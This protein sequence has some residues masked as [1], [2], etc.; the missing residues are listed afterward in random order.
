MLDLNSLIGTT[1]RPAWAMS[2]PAASLVASGATLAVGRPNVPLYISAWQT[3]ADNGSVSF[4]A[5]DTVQLQ[6][7]CCTAAG[8]ITIGGTL[9]ADDTTFTNNA[10]QSP[11]ITVE[12]GGDL[13]LADST[14]DLSSL[15]LDSGSAASMTLVSFSG[16]FKINSG[17]NVGTVANPTITGNDFSNVGANGIVASGDPNAQIPFSGN[18]WG[19]TVI[20]QIAAKIDD[21]NDNANLP[22]IAYQPFVS[23]ASGTVAS[24]VS[25]TF[26]PTNQTVNLTATVST[27]AGVAINEGTETFTILN[28]TQVIGQTTAPQNVSNGAVMA[29]YTLPG[30]T[31]AGQYIIEASYSG[32]AN[33]L[34]SIDTQHFLT[35]NPAATTTTVSNASATFNSASDQTVPLSAQISSMAGTVN[36]GTVTFTILFGGNPVGSP[37]TANVVNDAASASYD[38]LANTKGGS[39]TIETVYSDPV[40]FKT[41][42]GT[43]LLTVSAAP[44][45]ITPS[46]AATTFN[47]VTGEGITLSA[48][49][50]SPAGT[51][52]QGAVTFTILNSSSQQVVPPI[53]VNTL[54]GIASNNYILPAGTSVGSYTIAAVYDG[55]SSYAASLPSN[56]TLTISGA[57][58]SIAAANASIG[59][60]AAVQSA[61]LTAT[62]TSPGGT[63]SEGMVTFTILS[64]AT[65]IG[66]P[67][68]VNV[69]SGTAST[70]YPLPAAFALGTYTIK[71]VYNGTADFGG[72]ADSTHILT[73]TQPPAYQLVIGTPPS[74]AA[75]AGQALAVQPVIDEKDQF[76]NLE[77]GDNT[78]V[79]TATISTGPGSLLGTVTATVVGG[80]ATFTGLGDQTAGTITVAFSS[81]SLVPATTGN[82]V[83]SPAAASKL[84]VTQ[85]PPAGATAGQALA[86]QPVVKEEDQFGNVINTDSAHT[87][88]VA[89]GSVGTASVQG[90]NLTVTLVNG[91]ATFGGL[92]YDRAEMMDLSFT[93]N[94]SGVSSTSSGT[95]AVSP[96]A[97]SQLVSF[98]QPSATA[99]VGLAI[100]PGPVIYLEDQYNNIESGDNSTVV[101]AALN[102]GIGPLQDATTTVAGGVARFSNLID[103]R[104]ETI[105]LTFASGTL[106]SSPTNPIVVNQG[107]ASRLVIATQ[108]STTATAGQPFAV[109]PVI[110]IEDQGGNIE[111]TDNSTMVSVALSSGDGLP[112]GTT[113]VTVKNGVATFAGLK[114]T[115][116][117]IIALEFSGDGLTAGPSNNITV[118]PA[119]PFRLTIATQPSTTATAGQPFG[120]QPVIDELDLYGNLETTDSSTLITA[121]VTFGSGP[122][123]GTTTVALVGG[124]ATFTNLAETLV[125]HDCPRL[126][127]WRTVRRTVQPNRHQSRARRSACDRDPTLSGGD[128]G[129]RAYRSDR[130]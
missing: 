74:S 49:V 118:S 72:S 114:E 110:Y 14:Y 105:S 70:S 56:S 50:S 39:Y 111:T 89:R 6:G 129:A 24:P 59:Y 125:G 65:T 103:D 94:A 79:I 16:Q 122:L 99:T 66:T 45:T 106:T 78:T 87:V 38:L 2:F 25:R 54:N 128:R 123:P 95:I 36:E 57:T 30:N 63:V 7:N 104:A 85:E 42:T 82:I 47:T 86:T 27:T 67:V 9:T 124:V 83:I 4:A 68:A 90:S 88:T 73:V 28:G 93:T 22:T 98:Q 69:A 113:S 116:A 62:V 29:V 34:P 96:T 35:L 91:V 13:A 26:S 31:S 20:A 115:T 8:V 15:T 46:N 17:A 117:G 5:G 52:N 109:Q 19:T 100:A 32:T 33:Y 92:S 64:G 53:V 127:R 119:A 112:E 48:N 12:S 120:T 61:P 55:T 97:A 43:N 11:S 60:N 101:T 3:F 84:T 71:A 41:S 76:G 40:D 126:F 80:V 81:G 121:A 51:I 21:H 58:T 108:P 107:P 10:N 18:Y 130:D 1:T 23:G 77:T 102:T 44:T 75:T 37:V